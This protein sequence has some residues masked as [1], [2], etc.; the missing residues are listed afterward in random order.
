MLYL[1]IKYSILLYVSI[2]I[3]LYYMWSYI[4]VVII[5]IS[6][7]YYILRILGI[8]YIKDIRYI[9]YSNVLSISCNSIILVLHIY[10]L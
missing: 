8:L 7:L 4:M 3:L 9:K 5:G 10:Q 1:S 2:S 6:T